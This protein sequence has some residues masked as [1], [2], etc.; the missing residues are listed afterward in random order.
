[1]DI[2]TIGRFWFVR[3]DIGSTT[4]LVESKMWDDS[5]LMWGI[6]QHIANTLGM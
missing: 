3:V 1:M 4:G 2:P 6:I 5:M